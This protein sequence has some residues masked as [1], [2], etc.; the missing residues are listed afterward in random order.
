MNRLNGEVWATVMMFCS[1]QCLLRMELVSSTNFLFSCFS[2][3]LH[4]R[5]I[6]SDMQSQP[7]QTCRFFRN[8]SLSYR[9]IWLSKILALEYHEAAIIPPYLVVEALSPIF[10]R[11]LAIQALVSTHRWRKLP[12]RHAREHHISISRGL[13]SQA[14][15]FRTVKLLRGGRYMLAMV[16]EMI[17]F[18]FDVLR[19]K[20]VW[21]MSALNVGD[22]VADYSGMVTRTGS[23][24]VIISLRSAAYEHGVSNTCDAVEAL[25]LRLYRNKQ[26]TSKYSRSTLQRGAPSR[27]SYR[28]SRSPWDMT[29]LNEG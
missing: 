25:Q 23:V 9:V 14:A 11:R 5:A 22:V 17:L 19:R 13:A 3:P 15:G 21:K 10:L 26:S 12:V 1:V 2:Q 8:A 29:T 24:L 27:D 16:N 7:N 20:A 18:C 28:S 6:L 4:I